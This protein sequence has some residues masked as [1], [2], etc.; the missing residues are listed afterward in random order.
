MLRKK[1][2]MFFGEDLSYTNTKVQFKITKTQSW[3]YIQF[4]NHSKYRYLSL[5]IIHRFWDIITTIVSPPTVLRSD[6]HQS[7]SPLEQKHH[8]QSKH[9]K[10]TSGP[11][12]QM[13]TSS[14]RDSNRLST[15]P[16]RPQREARSAPISGGQKTNVWR[17]RGKSHSFIGKSDINGPCSTIIHGCNWWETTIIHGETSPYSVPDAP[18][19]EYW[20]TQMG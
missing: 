5:P 10:A 9:D 12:L 20:P 7:K 6:L 16:G 4:V 2:W 11:P 17:L 15:A 13:Q 14:P 3:G 1:S 8:E 19:L 18:C